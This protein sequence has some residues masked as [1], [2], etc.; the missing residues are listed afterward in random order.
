VEKVGRLPLAIA[1][2]A[3]FIRKTRNNFVVYY[4]RLCENLTKFLFR[5]FECSGKVYTDGVVSCWRLSLSEIPRDAA[6]LL[7]VCA[8]LAGE[9]IEREILSRWIKA[10]PWFEES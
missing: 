2:I 5:E 1:Q 6:R 3:S 8:F 10:M 7:N 4:K 9:G